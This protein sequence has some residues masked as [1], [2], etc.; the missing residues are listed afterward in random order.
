ME[1]L[2]TQSMTDQEHADVL[3]RW[4]KEIADKIHEIADEIVAHYEGDFD[5]IREDDAHFTFVSDDPAHQDI[6]FVIKTI[7]TMTDDEETHAYHIL[8]CDGLG[9][10]RTM[11][12]LMCRFVEYH[13]QERVQNRLAELEAQTTRS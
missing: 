4:T 7:R 11:T 1:H 12:G 8:S 2:P 13:L 3:S 5:A 6:D 10:H 9:D